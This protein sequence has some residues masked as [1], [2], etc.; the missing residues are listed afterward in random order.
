MPYSNTGRETAI[1]LVFAGVL[2]ILI[3]VGSIF[4]FKPEPEQ[5]RADDPLTQ[6]STESPT[7]SGT[8]TP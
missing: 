3:L 7:T 4:F 1:G 2:A 8:K 6:P 5:Q